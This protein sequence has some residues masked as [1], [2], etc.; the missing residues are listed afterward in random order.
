VGKGAIEI[1]DLCFEY[2]E[3][4]FAIH[5]PDLKIRKGEKV[6]F[7]GPSGC[8]KTTLVYLIAGILVPRSG[9]VFVNGTEIGSK[10]DVFRRRFRIAEIG[11]IF[12]DFELLDY[13]TTRGNMLLPYSVN[14]AIRP[15]KQVDERVKQLAASVGLGQM[16]SRHPGALSQGE[17]QRAAICRALITEPEIIIADEPTG[18]LDSANTS[19]IMDVM[20]S[21]AAQRNATF[22]MV[23]HDQS[24]YDRFDRVLD[25]RDFARGD[26]Q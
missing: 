19:A 5:V 12:Q 23:T 9:A 11:F 14:R 24:V 6:A 13:L 25:V 17:K 8:G 7:V 18:N 10:S 15:T 3:S 22:I 20:L 16:L 2:G 4:E 1:N 26:V 21:Q